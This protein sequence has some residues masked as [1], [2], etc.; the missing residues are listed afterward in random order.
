M[1]GQIA[2]R[3]VGTVHEEDINAAA[4]GCRVTMAVTKVDY[5]VNRR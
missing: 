1:D 4:A 3:S 2:N 5:W